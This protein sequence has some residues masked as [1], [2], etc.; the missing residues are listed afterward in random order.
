MSRR[1]LEYLQP[2]DAAL[3]HRAMPPR[4]PAPEGS[5]SPALLL[6]HGRGSNELDLLGLAQE[7][8]PRL[9]VISARAPFR[10]DYGFH[11]YGLLEVGR[12]EPR[13]FAQGLELLE[14]FSQQIVDG[15]GL[16]PKRLFLLGFSQGAMMAGSLTL[17]APERVAGTVMLS[18][19]LPLHTGLEVEPARLAGQP[20]FIAHGAYDSV[21][22]IGFGREAKEYLADLGAELTYREYPIDHQVSDWELRD[23]DEWLTTRLDAAKAGDEE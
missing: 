8:D 20:F 7:L 10:L 19:Y 11:W 13:S 4:T 18:G 16:D 21:I 22:P 1:T 17:K 3:V 5:A 14:E 2:I 15:Y 6:L 23:V 12:P 9:L